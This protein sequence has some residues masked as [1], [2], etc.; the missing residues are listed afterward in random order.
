M[1]GIH[2]IC[3]NRA[4][5]VSMIAWM[6]VCSHQHPV[7]AY[8][9]YFV[10]L[11]SNTPPTSHPKVH[12]LSTSLKLFSITFPVSLFSPFFLFSL[13]SLFSFFFLLSLIFCFSLSLLLFH[14]SLFSYS[15]LLFLTS[16]MHCHSSRYMTHRNLV[17][18]FL[19]S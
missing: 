16:T 12:L 14:S 17:R 7:E 8:L 13:F 5:F 3:G 9:L 19:K 10:F 6:T 2:K 11:R 18:Q 4:C 1:V 15:S